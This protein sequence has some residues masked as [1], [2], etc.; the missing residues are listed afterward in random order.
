MFELYM[1]RP[2]RSVFGLVHLN[3]KNNLNETSKVDVDP[4]GFAIY[5]AYA[6]N[7]SSF[8]WTFLKIIFVKTIADQIIAD[9][10]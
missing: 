9:P 4:R 2:R 5:Q 3:S 6:M 1:P 10:F 7:L 8:I